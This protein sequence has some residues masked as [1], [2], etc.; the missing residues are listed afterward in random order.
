MVVNGL[1]DAAGI[2]AKRNMSVL[3][4]ES[5]YFMTLIAKGAHKPAE[6]AM[7]PNCP[8]TFWVKCWRY[9]GEVLMVLGRIATLSHRWRHCS[10]SMLSAELAILQSQPNRKISF[11]LP[12]IIS[13][14]TSNPQLRAGQCDRSNALVLCNL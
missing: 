6:G 9:E 1:N 8:N 14:T 2:Q 11:Q 7:V 10:A 5:T 13:L 3:R 4:V 12:S